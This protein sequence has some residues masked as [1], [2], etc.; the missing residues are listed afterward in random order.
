MTI[1][2]HFTCISCALMTACHRLSRKVS[3]CLF[4]RTPNQ[5]CILMD[6]QRMLHCALGM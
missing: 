3:C 2:V 5:N 1:F 6:F 4:L